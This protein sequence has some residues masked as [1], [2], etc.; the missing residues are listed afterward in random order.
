MVGESLYLIEDTFIDDCLLILFTSGLCG[1]TVR[2][3]AR[4]PKDLGFK[5]RPVR[6]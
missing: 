2:A 1:V 3:F 6:F 4:D 5:S